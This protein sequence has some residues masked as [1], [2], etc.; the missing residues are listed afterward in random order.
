MYVRTH[1]VVHRLISI[2]SSYIRMYIYLFSITENV[3]EVDISTEIGESLQSI[4][5]VCS[6]SIQLHM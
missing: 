5:Q 4:V 2:C 3:V 1:V 6:S